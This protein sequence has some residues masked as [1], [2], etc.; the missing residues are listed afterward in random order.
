MAARPW[1][2]RI[3]TDKDFSNE[4]ASAKSTGGEIMSS[5]ARRDTNSDKPSPAAS[6]QARQS[7]ATPPSRA[8]SMSGRAVKSAS[9]RAS[10]PPPEDDTRSTVSIQSERYRRH[11]VAGSSVRDDESVASLASSPA[12]P[13]YMAP[14]KSARA[15]TRFQS[16]MAE[17]I[18]EVTPER[19]T[20]VGSAKKRLSFPMGEKHGV[21]SP[22]VIR[23]HSG[24]PKV[25]GGASVKIVPAAVYAEQNGGSR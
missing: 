22:A 25:E 8:P 1:E 23:R 9:P 12:V 17:K 18:D 6:K 13:S 10:W 21:P 15:R 7:P 5:Y 11:S 24:P 3:P 14:T 4:H 16:E 20:P 19:V 2:S